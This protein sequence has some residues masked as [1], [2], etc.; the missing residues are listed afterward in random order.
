M[1][2]ILLVLLSITAILTLTACGDDKTEE[3]PIENVDIETSSEPEEVETDSE[4]SETESGNEVDDFIEENDVQLD[5]DG[6]FAETSDPLEAGD[7]TNGI[8]VFNDEFDYTYIIKEWYTSEDTDEKGSNTMDFDGY[9]VRYSVALLENTAEEDVIGIF[10]ETENNTDKVV[11]YN[12]DL[13]MLTSEQEQAY[14]D[15]M[16][17]IG[18]SKPGVKTKGFI[19]VELEYDTPDSF[20]VTFEPPWDD[21]DEFN[22]EIGEPIE[23]EFNKE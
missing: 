17:G 6:F 14:S 22:A 4:E 5:E 8:V 23:L 12:M 18:Q 2:K 15:G 10:V 11:Q 7:K 1:K 21:E 9:E 19:L 16:Y 20:T 3:E 13:E